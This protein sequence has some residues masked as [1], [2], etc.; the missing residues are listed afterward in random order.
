MNAK[1]RCNKLSLILLLIILAVCLIAIAMRPN[2]YLLEVTGVHTSYAGK[3][4]AFED[5][6]GYFVETNDG[7]LWELSENVAPG[8]TL[9]M[10]NNGTEQVED[11][12]IISV[13]TY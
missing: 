6:T 10:H 13:I 1:N 12:V 9:V 11:D 3:M 4:L 8:N 2:I 7:N 5:G